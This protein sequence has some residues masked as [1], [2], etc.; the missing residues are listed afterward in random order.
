MLLTIF[1]IFLLFALFLIAF[2][3]RKQNAPVLSL[4]FLLIF[5]IGFLV[6]QS[7]LEIQTGI[8]TVVERDV[9]KNSDLDL[10]NLRDVNTPTPSVNQFLKWNGTFWYADANAGTGGGGTDH[11]LLS[12]THLDTNVG[13]VQRGDLIIGNSTPDWNRRS[14]GAS[15][16]YLRSDGI[17]ALWTGLTIFDDT[18]PTLAGDLL[19]GSFNIL[20]RAG[21]TWGSEPVPVAI[22]GAN[23]NYGFGI[24]TESLYFVL[25]N[26]SGSTAYISGIL[27]SGAT[28]GQHIYISNGGTDDV[29]FNDNNSDS[30]LIY[31]LTLSTNQDM[32]LETNES[33]HFVYDDSFGT[34]RNF[35]EPNP[36]TTEGSIMV[37]NSVP[38]W[39][40][41]TIGADATYLRSNSITPEWNSLLIS[42][43]TAPSL[44]A[45]LDMNNHNIQ[46]D[47]NTGI[48]TDTNEAIVIFRDGGAG[49]GRNHFVMR[50]GA[51]GG[52]VALTSEGEINTG[53]SIF[54]AGTGTVKLGKG[55]LEFPNSDGGAGQVLQT[56]GSATLSFGTAPSPAYTEE[57][58]T[59]S[60]LGSGAWEDYNVESNFGIVTGQVCTFVVENMS[61]NMEREAGVR[62]NGSSKGRLFDLHEAETGGR[63]PVSLTTQIGTGSVIEIYAEAL[64]DVNFT[65]SGCWA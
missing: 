59:F 16:R 64:G 47:N 58:E 17:D 33:I 4:G 28:L 41:K 2:G 12:S 15:G 53:L 50:N 60:A 52:D 6:L 11:N 37:G 61:G 9:P 7:G 34:W 35:E 31:Q 49:Q 48:F 18:N 8:T 10:N 36:K 24:A 51:T 19:A 55:M 20:Q 5:L 42:D 27:T 14:L 22:T 56:N 65:L 29:V 44:S 39:N 43:D 54:G 30:S 1:I 23:S 32:T 26:G 45:S 46:F 13:F 62:T 63:T 25:V 57:F 21:G 3:W 40:E 38:E